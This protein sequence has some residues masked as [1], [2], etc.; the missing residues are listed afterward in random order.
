[1]LGLNEGLTRA[2]QGEVNWGQSA[3]SEEPFTLPRISLSMK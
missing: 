3:I 1:M 2:S